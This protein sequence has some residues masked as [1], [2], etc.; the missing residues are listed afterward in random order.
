MFLL[1]DAVTDTAIKDGEWCSQLFKV[2]VTVL[3]GRTTK[4]LIKNESETN[5]FERCSDHYREVSSNGLNLGFQLRS[6]SCASVFLWIEY[7]KDNKEY[8]I[9]LFIVCC[10]RAFEM[11]IFYVID[12]IKNIHFHNYGCLI[13]ISEYTMYTFFVFWAY[14]FLKIKNTLLLT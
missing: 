13:T 9:Y 6:L 5:Y 8:F 1:L 3:V 14:F 4:P 12:L 11:F 2:F 7:F 10:F